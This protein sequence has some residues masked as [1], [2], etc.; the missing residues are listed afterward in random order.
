MNL[1]CANCDNEAVAILRKQDGTMLKLCYTCREAWQWG[2]RDGLANMF[3]DAIGE[4][5]WYESMAG[6]IY[7]HFYGDP[8]DPQHRAETIPA[9]EDALSD[10]ALLF[11]TEQELFDTWKEYDEQKAA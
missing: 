1:Y 7:S 11:S 10:G 4:D 2:Y 9:I 6:M 3:H 5:Y 8:P